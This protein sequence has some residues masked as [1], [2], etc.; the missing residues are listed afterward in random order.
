M[1]C[2]SAEGEFVLQFDQVLSIITRWELRSVHNRGY[3]AVIERNC[4]EKIFKQGKAKTGWWNVIATDFVYNYSCCSWKQE[5]DLWNVYWL[6]VIISRFYVW[7]NFIFILL[8]HTHD[9]SIAGSFCMD[10]SEAVA[11]STVSFISFT[12]YMPH[13]PRPFRNMYPCNRNK[14]CCDGYWPTNSPNCRQC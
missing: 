3:L 9:E 6:F 14:A 1:F 4:Q 7:Q 10:R 2:L 11:I 12:F 8:I 5:K 13:I